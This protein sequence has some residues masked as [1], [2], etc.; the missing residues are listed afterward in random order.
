MNVATRRL[1]GGSQ[2]LMKTLMRRESGQ[3]EAEAS[4]MFAGITRRLRVRSFVAWSSR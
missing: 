1:R 2:T 3:Y 4:V